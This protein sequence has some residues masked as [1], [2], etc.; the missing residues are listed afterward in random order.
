[1]SAPAFSPKTAPSPSRPAPPAPAPATK[2]SSGGAGAGVPRFAATTSSEAVDISSGTFNPSEKVKGEIAE[3]PNKT[4]DVRVFAKGLTS[5]GRVKVRV[6]SNGNYDSHGL[7]GSMPLLNPWTQQL[8]GMHLNF[9]VKS[10]EIKGGYASLKPGGGDTNDWL[11]AVQKNAELLGG[12]GLKIGHLP[13]PVNK[14]ENGVL[15]LGVTGL[16]VEVGGFLDADFNLL[17]E[18][19]SKLKVDGTGKINVKGIVEGTLKLDN[20]Q[21]KL[22]GEV[23]L[24]VNFKSFS[25]SALIKY[26]PDGTVD[27]NGKA[28]YSADRLSG[29]IGFVAT[30][31][32]SA[33][34]FARS[35]ISAAGGLENV[36]A[37]APPEPVP[38]PKPGKKARALAATGQLAFNLTNWFA[39]TVNV[40][41]DGEGKI[42]VIG[43]IA[44]PAEIELFKQ[45]DWDKELIKFEA[46]AYYGIPV[47]GDLNLFANISLYAIAKLG[48]AKIY[49]IEILGTYSTDPEIQKNIQI[50]GSINISAYAGLRLRAEGGAGVEIASHELKFGIGLNADV[51]I[52][53]Y[54]DARP[55]VGFRDP[56][57]FYISG[58]LEMVAQPMLGLGGDFFIEL[59][60]PWWS[61]LSDDKWIWPLFSKEWPLTDPIGL[62]ATVKDYV[63]GSGKVPEIELKKPEFDPSKFMTSMVDKT[64]P[65]K[66]GGRDVGQG[67]FKEDGSVQKPV[68]PPKKPAPP[69][70]A[71]K[72]GKKASPPNAGKSG[73]PDP[74]SG[75]EKDIG[76]NLKKAASL[77]GNLKGKYSRE[78]LHTEL[79]KI[80]GQMKGVE[81]DVQEKP[82][83]WAV[84]PKA[85]KKPGKKAI[86]LSAKDPKAKDPKAQDPGS[87]PTNAIQWHAKETAPDLDGEQHS[88]YLEGEPGHV[89]LKVASAPMDVDA[90]IKLIRDSKKLKDSEKEKLVKQAQVQHKII[91]DAVKEFTKLD[92]DAHTPGNKPLTPDK[93]AA[94]IKEIS[95]ENREMRAA[96]RA[97]VKILADAVFAGGSQ[98]DL[99]ATADIRYKLAKGT[100]LQKA[101]SVELAPLSAKRPEDGTEPSAEPVGWPDIVKK[102][103]TTNPPH[104]VRL[105]LINRLFRG[106][107]TEIGNLVPGSKQNNSDHLRSVETPL[108]DL[109]GSKPMES[110]K[111][112]Q[113]WY[114][115]SVRYYSDG[116]K[117][118]WPT[119]VKV[120]PDDFAEFID[121]RWGL[122]RWHGH[123]TRWKKEGA[124]V[125]NFTLGPIPLPKLTGV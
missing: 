73:K 46:K 54:A 94:E 6:G 123:K 121:F 34:S 21:D 39:G 66:S 108:K 89:K 32:E 74:N 2:P 60:T 35:A 106:P 103:L 84:T 117:K 119:I 24:A 115:A 64:L 118:D 112:A 83:K 67:T 90:A 116:E 114:T 37:A 44:P 62:S 70:Q 11:H 20:S 49:N 10:N 78:E 93:K 4:L 18:N 13:A 113:V 36:Q 8:G 79:G 75:K 40:V 86:E 76:A 26:N 120:K 48:P 122:Y 88:V 96:M 81:F 77:L 105:H 71:K 30:D 80:K 42:T 51:G 98:D 27:I 52:K 91:D 9:T 33:K 14:F 7:K 12:L 55:T 17:L 63:L 101:H 61:P 41:V 47:V 109:V 53:A 5:E 19:T 59:S 69:K 50:S 23:S 1:M 65:D 72:A 102:Q 57:E 38:A 29:E 125:G 82:G 111:I 45:R 25:G 107:G 31:I 28:A 22:A 95:E 56:G 104:Y 92:K 15:T 97:L 87:D 110:G 68:V 16:K 100:G 3:Q 99:D 124:A 85:G 58:T 43:K